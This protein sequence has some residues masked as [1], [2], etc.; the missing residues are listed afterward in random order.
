MHADWQLTEPSRAAIDAVRGPLLLEFG[1]PGCGHCIAA[2]PLIA[3]A[4][5]EHAALAHLKIAD[6]PGQPLGRAFRVKLWPTLVFLHD[7][8]EMARVVRPAD[9]AELRAAIAVLQSASHRARE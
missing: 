4:L 3:Q 5:S 1:R 2:T 8:R 7:G 9:L 6:G